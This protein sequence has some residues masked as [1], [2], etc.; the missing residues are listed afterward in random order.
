MSLITPLLKQSATL[1][2]KTATDS[3]GTKTYS[4]S[5]IACRFEKMIKIFRGI[6]G[7]EWRSEAHVFS[8]AELMEGDQFTVGGET[9][10]IQKVSHI[11]DLDGSITF[12][13]GWL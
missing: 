12:Y 4:T 10:D 9:R 2:R 3:W 7:E 11:P 6:E 13:E 5:T 1:K 8:D